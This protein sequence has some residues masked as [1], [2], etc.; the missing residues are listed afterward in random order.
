MSISKKLPGM[1]KGEEIQPMKRK[2]I[3]WNPE[4]KSVT[5]ETTEGLNLMRVLETNLFA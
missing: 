2:P 4:L 5:T 3:H 1:Q